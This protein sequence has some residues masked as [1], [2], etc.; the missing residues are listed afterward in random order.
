MVAS[1]R[2][3]DLED[4]LGADAQREVVV[5]AASGDDH[6]TSEQATKAG[7]ALV[8]WGQPAAST[9]PRCL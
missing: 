2:M 4:S 6:K 1:L 9:P 7:T 5:V 3:L 8:P